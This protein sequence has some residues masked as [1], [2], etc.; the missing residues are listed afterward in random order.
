MQT[1]YD[2]LLA[3][4]H[5]LI[6]GTFFGLLLYIY[7]LS[8]RIFTSSSAKGE[9]ERARDRAVESHKTVIDEAK[10]ML[11]CCDTE[12]VELYAQMSELMLMKQWFL[13]EGVAWVVKLVQK[14]P[15]LEK[16]DADLVNSVNVVGANEGIKQGFKA[17][18][19]SV[20]SVEEVPGYDE[21]AQATLDAAVKAFDELEIS[22]LGKVAD[23]IDKPLHVIQQ[24][25]KLPIVEE[26]DD[27]IE[28]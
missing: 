3:D 2:Q 7:S 6:T 25:S 24:R 15:K 14:S 13:T 16:V 10:G 11:S 1:S 20:R 27:V 12:M 21:G 26:D 9:L 19:D 8:Y 18:H 22:V 28:V 4:Y 5:R 17:A 23:L